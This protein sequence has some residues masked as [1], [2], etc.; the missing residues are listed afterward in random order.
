MKAYK[1]KP[2]L[3]VADRGEDS[4]FGDDFTFE[5]AEELNRLLEEKVLP[6]IDAEEEQ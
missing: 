3:T 5:Q 6:T 2:V 4:L 1:I